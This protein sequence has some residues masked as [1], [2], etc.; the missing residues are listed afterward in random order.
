MHCSHSTPPP[1]S[2]SRTKV[3]DDESDYF[4]VE[5]NQWISSDQREALQSKDAAL[6]E[7]KYGSRR[8]KVVT[9]DIAGKQ[10][11]KEEDVVG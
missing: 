1:C 11:L 2:A 6:R 10:V 7:A 4:S 8:N 5:T 9:L 3:I